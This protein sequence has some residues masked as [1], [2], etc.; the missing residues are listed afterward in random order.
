MTA[1]PIW[2]DRGW[3]PVSV[4]FVPSQ[5]AWEHLQKKYGLD[6]SW[7]EAANHGGYTVRYTNPNDGQSFIVVA[8]F[9]AAE[10]DAAEVIFTLVHEAV[11][12]WQFICQVIGEKSAGIEM[13]AYGI[14]HFSRGLVEAYRATMG[15]G[16][17]WA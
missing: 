8:L 5:Q 7:P 13:E 10:R 4:A 11:H 3:Q 16:K 1:K 2:L 9:K 17:E 15:K 14:E 6:E 12:V